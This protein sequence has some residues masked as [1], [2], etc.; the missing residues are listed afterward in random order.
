MGEMGEEPAGSMGNDTPLAVLSK[1]PQLLFS[2][3]RQM[4]AQVTNPAIDPIREQ[5][6][7]S[8]AMNLGPQGNLLEETAAQIETTG[9]KALVA[10]IDLTDRASVG[11]CAQYI[12]DRWGGVDLLD[13]GAVPTG[14]LR[15]SQA[16]ILL[17]ALL[18]RYRNPVRAAEELARRTEHPF[19]ARIPLSLAGRKY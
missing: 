19:G 12:L 4:F 2:Y 10:A 18:A 13:A 6:V 3:F 16:R 14:M 8:L 7:M 17:T 11:A 1:R 9:A 15:P 5:L